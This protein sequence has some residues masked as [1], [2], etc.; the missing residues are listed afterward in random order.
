[1]RPLLVALLLATAACS[2][3]SQW[4]SPKPHEPSFDGAQAVNPAALVTH[5][6][7]L[8]DVLGCTGC[9]GDNLQGHQFEPKMT[10]YGPVYASNLTLAVPQYSDAQLSQIVREGL[11]P[12]RKTVWIMPSQV[13]QHLSDRDFKALFAYLRTLK[14]AGKTWPPPRFST[15]DKKE[16]A[17]GDYKPAA[18][19]VR[20]TAN[21][22][23]IDVGPQYALGRY[24]TEVTCAECHG[25]RLEGN[26]KNG[27]PP[28]LIVAGG[29]TRAEF[30]RLITEGIPTGGR[31]LRPLMAAVAKYRF[32]HLTRHERDALYAYL[33]ARAGQQQ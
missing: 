27:I 22:L 10:Q 19:L 14:P 2:K 32:S 18:Q 15:E 1:M 7:R 24:I 3:A 23:P 4:P 30:E 13:F 9:H 8:T 6:R 31:T 25:P 12:K 5:G 33:K 11:H 21:Q 16:I 28:N 20:E 17:S 26:P 29:Y